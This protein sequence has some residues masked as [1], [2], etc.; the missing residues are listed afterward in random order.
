M[1]QVLFGV[2]L[3]VVVGVI[4][5][6]LFARRN[7]LHRMH[8]DPAAADLGLAVRIARVVDEDRL[9]APDR[10]VDA[11]ALIQ[12]E[13]EGVM[14]ARLL[15]HFRAPV[16]LGIRNLFAGV[17]DDAGSL[18]DILDREGAHSLNRRAA[19]LEPFVDRAELWRRHLMVPGL[20]RTMLLAP[21]VGLSSSL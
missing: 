18:R 20:G 16:G 5:R 12:N 17:F 14:P 6:Q 10:P 9:I 1:E 19:E 8:P 13:K 4:V 2:V 15:L 7:G 11:L 21:D 3:L